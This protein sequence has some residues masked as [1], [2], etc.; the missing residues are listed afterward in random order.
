MI[1]DKELM[2]GDETSVLVDGPIVNLGSLVNK[3]EYQGKGQIIPV[4]MTGKNLVGTDPYKIV[5]EDSLDGTTWSSISTEIGIGLQGI[6]D[7]GVSFGLP[8]NISKYIRMS[9]TG[10]TAGTF[11]AGIVMDSLMGA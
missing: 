4:Y 11:T 8:S 1:F 7:G 2:L 6:L 9:V 3:V 10:F 5:I